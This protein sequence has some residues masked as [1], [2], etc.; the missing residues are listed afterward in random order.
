M[1]RCAE[2]ENE[3]LAVI[4]TDK[5]AVHCSNCGVASLPCESE[6]AAEDFW[7]RRASI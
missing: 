4:L 1:H 7:N 2:L 5:V 3:T 6:K